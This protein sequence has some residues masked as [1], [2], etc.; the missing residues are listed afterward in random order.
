MFMFFSKTEVPTK[1]SVF[2]QVAV[3]DTDFLRCFS[4]F[5]LELKI[6]PPQFFNDGTQEKKQP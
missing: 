5:V 3:T 1:K 6:L 2:S 4:L